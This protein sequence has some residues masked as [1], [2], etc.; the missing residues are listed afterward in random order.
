M[1]K[2]H[3]CILDSLWGDHRLVSRLP[4]SLLVSF[5]VQYTRTK[6]LEELRTLNC[7]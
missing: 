4:G 2:G 3:S 6:E 1:P 5:H 7:M